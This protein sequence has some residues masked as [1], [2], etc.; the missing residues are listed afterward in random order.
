[1]APAR[2]LEQL[3]EHQARRWDLEGRIARPSSTRP[4]IAISRL[5]GSG[6]AEL[7]RRTAEKLDYG[8]FD[9]ELLDQIAREQGVQRRLLEGLDEHV[10][11][12]IERYVVDAFSHRAF[13]ESEYLRA[14][15]RAIT[16]LG[17][18]G[19]AVILG[20]GAP[21]ILPSDRALRLLVVAPKA[22]RTARFARERG[23]SAADAARALLREDAERRH[24]LRHHFAID[25]DDP[26]LYDVVVNTETL[27]LDGAA[28]VVIDALKRRF[29]L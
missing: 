6:A 11:S 3:V 20:R 9:I 13:T 12:G 7:G 16:A 18:R 28:A 14:V 24:F 17:E 23:L 21:F 8:F 27:G 26:V 5:P 29:G 4:C 2:R 1:M 10:R 15:V 22:A 25:P 19:S